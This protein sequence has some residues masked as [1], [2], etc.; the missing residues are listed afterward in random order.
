MRRGYGDE[1]THAGLASEHSQARVHT[2]SSVQVEL[3]RSA[4]AYEERCS[5]DEVA[6]DCRALVC[7]RDQQ[8]E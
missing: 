1:E 7:D 5:V 4:D 8:M 6:H 3:M 2:S